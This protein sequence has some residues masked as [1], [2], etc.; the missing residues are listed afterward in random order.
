MASSVE[1]NSSTLSPTPIEENSPTLSPAPI[2]DN[3]P[4]LSLTQKVMQYWKGALATLVTA[5][6]I[7]TCVYFP[8][9]ALYLSPAVEFLV[10]SLGLTSIWAGFAAFASVVIGIAAA[11]F[12]ATRLLLEGI[13]A[14]VDKCFGNETPSN[15][16][17][18]ASQLVDVRNASSENDN[19]SAEIVQQPSEPEH[20]ATLFVLKKQDTADASVTNTASATPSDEQQEST[21]TPTSA[22]VEEEMTSAP[23]I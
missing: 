10:S 9:A 2:E 11:T 1:D 22:V 7:A 14:L 19:G 21:V 6:A 15:N 18:D 12:G 8:P 4:T 13:D 23:A 20:H 17:E 16:E 3:S 5:G